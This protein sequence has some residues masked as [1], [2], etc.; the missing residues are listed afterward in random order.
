MPTDDDQ[1]RLAQFLDNPA[2]RA[3]LGLLYGRRRIGKSTLLV[4]EVGRRGGFYFEATR[5]QTPVQLQRLGAELGARHGVGRLALDGWEEAITHLLRLG[6]DEQIPV[7]LDEF[8][9]ILQA[10]PSVDSVLATALGPA[11]RRARPSQA[12]LV[13]C[14]SAIAM[15][16]ALTAGEAPLR[17]RASLELVMHADDYRVAATRLPAPGQH[18]LAVALYS[19]IGGVVGYATDMVGHE[20]PAHGRGLRWLG[21]RAGAVTG[22]AAA[23]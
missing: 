20:L 13:L 23:P 17:G 5:V 10:D 8:G 3:M 11:A 16:R 15:M 18:D 2:E 12:R 14:G 22:L 1:R 19:V 9:H 6:A 21:R 4:D 7:V